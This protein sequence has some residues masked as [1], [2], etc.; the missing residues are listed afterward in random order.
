MTIIIPSMLMCPI[1]FFQ[2]TVNEC[3]NCD[4]IKQIIIIDN[5]INK[6]VK[7]H[8]LSHPKI[9]IVENGYNIGVNKAWNL[10][11]N[12]CNTGIYGVINDD[13]LCY[14]NIFSQAYNV[15]MKNENIGILTI[16]YLDNDPLPS[17]DKYITDTKEMNDLESFRIIPDHDWLGFA[18]FG[19][20]NRWK[21]IEDLDIFFG[22]N[23]IYRYSLKLGYKNAQLLNCYAVHKKFSTS[24]KLDSIQEKQNEVIKNKKVINEE[25]IYFNLVKKYDLPLFGAEI[26]LANKYWGIK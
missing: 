23:F 8:I 18:F 22:D 7:N 2:Y 16:P 3:C 21:D 9:N 24:H 20:K 4:I 12:L 19:K 15:L 11:V 1:D 13:L 26:D 5:T 25:K 10:G 14:R 17:K 6:S